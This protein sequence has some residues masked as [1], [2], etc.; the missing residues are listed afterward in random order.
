MLHRKI[1]LILNLL[2]QILNLL[3]H[4]KVL[5]N[6]FREIKLEHLEVGNQLFQQHQEKV[7][8][9]RDT[10]QMPWVCL[11]STESFRS[12]NPNSKSQG[13]VISA[14]ELQKWSLNITRIHKQVK[15]KSK[16]SLKW[17]LPCLRR[18]KVSLASN[19]KLR[20]LG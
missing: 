4:W 17:N 14:K 6:R 5:D 3:F 8:R 7:P 13:R 19:N 1:R 18:Q 9:R 10:C 20:N 15:M 16:W 12:L 2:F 11:N